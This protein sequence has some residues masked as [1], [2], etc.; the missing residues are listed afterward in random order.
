MWPTIEAFL[1]VSRGMFELIK[2]NVPVNQVNEL[3]IMLIQKGITRE[4]LFPDLISS[5]AH[6]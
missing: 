4:F 3:K 5:D 2:I 1:P 6:A